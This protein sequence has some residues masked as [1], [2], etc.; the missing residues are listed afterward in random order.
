MSQFN[1]EPKNLGE[2]QEELYRWQVYNFAE[3][4]P[5]R[6][7]LGV[8]EEAGELCHAQLKLEQGIRGS[9]EEKLEEMKDAIGD[10]CMYAMN[11]CSFS[12]IPFTI[13]SPGG[14]LVPGVP[15]M[16]DEDI[17]KKH[18]ARQLVFDVFRYAASISG[19]IGGFARSPAYEGVA[20]FPGSVRSLSFSLYYLCRVNDWDLGEIILETWQHIGQRDWKQFPKNGKTE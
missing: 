10:I 9:K 19:E 3:Q 20:P 2:L 18:T 4:D 8:C 7:V 17:K 1:L 14:E 12:K 5:G 16:S 13:P 11:L 6:M 15:V